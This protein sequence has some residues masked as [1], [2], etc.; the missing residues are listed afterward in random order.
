MSM[1]LQKMQRTSDRQVESPGLNSSS[2]ISPV[3]ATLYTSTNNGITPQDMKI[4][5]EEAGNVRKKSSTFSSE[6]ETYD[7]EKPD[8]VSHSK[9]D[10]AE[11][12][13]VAQSSKGTGRKAFEKQQDIEDTDLGNHLDNMSELS[14]ASPDGYDSE[15]S[16]ARKLSS[17]EKRIATA[18]LSKKERRLLQNRK[19]ALKCRL[20]KQDQ[21]SGFKG[22]L[23]KLSDEN[24]QLKEQVSTNIYYCS[25]LL[26]KIF[27]SFFTIKRIK[28]HKK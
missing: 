5:G 4:V 13:K 23:G 19:S 26:T 9:G 12:T 20:K 15:E 1:L 7:N 18:N 11:I 10:A 14:D 16:T 6:I 28:V 25:R 21:L 8:H 22:K 27:F 2:K 3:S 17:I 24:S